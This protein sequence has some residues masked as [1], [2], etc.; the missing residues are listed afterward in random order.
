MYS[1]PEEYYFRIHHIR[2]RFKDQVEDVLLYLA[3]AISGLGK[4]KKD[5]FR[6]KLY[7][8]IRK[9]PGNSHKVKKTINNWRTEITSLFGFVEFDG[10]M[11]FP[12]RRA[13]E[14]S[15]TQDL[16]EFF[17]YFLFTFQYPGGFLKANA[18]QE[19][20]NAG[21]HFKPVKYILRVLKAA[22]EI[23]GR[24][25][26]ITKAETCHCILNDLRCARDN[27]DPIIVWNRIK[28]HRENNT[29]YDQEGDVVRYAGDIIDYMVIANLLRSYNN[30]EFYLN[31][32]E[33]ENIQKFIASSEWFSCYDKMIAQRQADIDEI[34][35]CQDKWFHYVNRDMDSTDF[36]TDIIAILSD[37]NEEY[38]TLKRDAL[39]ETIKSIEPDQVSIS[40]KEI[41]DLGEAIIHSH[42]CK[43]L[44]IGGRGDLV[45][46]V[47]RMPTNLAVGYDIQSIEL[48]EKKRYIEVKTTISSKPL[49]FNKVHLT[50]NEWTT[51]ESCKSI[52]FIYRLSVN[53][54]ENKLHLIQDPVTLYKKDLIVMVPRDGADITFDPKT[55]GNEE[56]LL[57]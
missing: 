7:D 18:I 53:R 31:S 29:E 35:S 10:E 13:I 44:L 38:T 55:V 32:V 27:E 17:K 41:G 42:E 57:I 37:N 56:K 14:L 51:A 12:G 23:E 8:L 4:Q 52:Y 11:A 34:K 45:H 15:N 3:D 6:D 30:Q 1:V 54:I 39:E 9:F 24:N 16:V 5:E 33:E 26:G 20:I 21:V 40:P 48:D 50:T 36:K 2:S 43:K 28:R 49:S 25:I 47:K 22:N 19:Q 46:L